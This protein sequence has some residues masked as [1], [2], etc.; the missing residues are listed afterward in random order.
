[1]KTKYIKILLVGNSY[2]YKNDY[3]RLLSKLLT[4]AGYKNI[5]AYATRGGKPTLYTVSSSLKTDVKFRAWKNGKIY[6]NSKGVKYVAEPKDGVTLWSVLNRTYGVKRQKGL[7]DYIVVQNNGVEDSKQDAKDFKTICSRLKPYIVSPN[8]FILTHMHYHSK[9]A[10]SAAKD[11]KCYYIDMESIFKQYGEYVNVPWKKIC[12]I[13]DKEDH[14]SA[15]GM[16]LRALATYV[17][18]AG[19]KKLPD[20][21]KSKLFISVYAKDSGYVYGTLIHVKESTNKNPNYK[22]ANIITKANA[23]KMQY[24]IR[25]KCLQYI[26]NYKK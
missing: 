8:Q 2:T 7:W 15:R 18:I 14:P 1:M 5:V 23:K 22:Y 25:S 19:A 13:Q 9:G 16:Y 21:E 6:K 3:G 10:K 11:L 24:F 26:K 17:A 12:T 4:K 20:T